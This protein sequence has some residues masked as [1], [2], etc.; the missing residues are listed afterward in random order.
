MKKRSSPSRRDKLVL[1]ATELFRRD[2]YSGT[3]VSDICDWAGVTKGAFFHHFASKEELAEASLEL[4]DHNVA[5]M[6][7][8]APFQSVAS[9]KDKVA[10]YMDFFIEL[11]SRPD[12]IKSCLVGTT[13]QEVAETNPALRQASQRC[14][15]H[16]EARF[17]AIMSNASPDVDSF[18]LARLWMATVQGS[19]LLYKASGDESVIPDNLKHVRKYILDHF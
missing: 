10:A 17:A 8:A 6:E 12:L 5:A 13:V 1:A 16:A 9:G 14:F 18:A 15:D 7:A 3:S 2:G 19:L 4:W 11:F